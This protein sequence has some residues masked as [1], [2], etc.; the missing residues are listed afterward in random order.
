MATKKAAP[1][2]Q[3]VHD[4]SANTPCEIGQFVHCAKCVEEW[5]G[6]VTPAEWARTQTGLTA[7]GFQVWCTRHDCNSTNVVVQVAPAPATIKRH[8]HD[9]SD[10]DVCNTCDALRAR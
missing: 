10:G 9:F 7:K 4:T 8:R 6:D 5:P 2:V 3:F 1:K